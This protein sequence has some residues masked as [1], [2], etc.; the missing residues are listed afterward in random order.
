[1]PDSDMPG[2]EQL[3]EGPI[4]MASS[5]RGHGLNHMTSNMLGEERSLWGQGPT[6]Q[7]SVARHPVLSALVTFC[8]WPVVPTPL[9]PV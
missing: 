8:T 4:C 5:R 9:M 1:M 2:E 3:G 6:L 7:L